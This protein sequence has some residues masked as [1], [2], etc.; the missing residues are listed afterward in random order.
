MR[1]KIS[2]AF[3]QLAVAK[4]ADS[5][6]IADA[7][8]TTIQ[9]L[10]KK[11]YDENVESQVIVNAERGDIEVYILK[12]IVETVVNPKLEISVEDAKAV[13]E[14]LEVG[15]EYPEGGPINS[16]DVQKLFTRKSIGAIKQTVQQRIRA[17]ERNIL[18]NECL[19]MVGEVITGEVYQIHSDEIILTYNTAKD[20]QIELTLLNAD[21]IDKDNPRKIK[22]MKVYVRAVEREKDREDGPIKVFVSRRDAN[23]LRK[24]FE[25]EVPEIQEGLIVIKKIVRS[26]GERAKVA[27]ESTNNR[28]DPVGAC[29]GH[30]GKRIQNIVKELNNENIDVIS[31]SEEPQI[32]IGRALQPAKI[33]P[34]MVHA[35]PKTK[36]AR[37]MLRPDQIKYAIG[38]NGH[39]IRLAQELTGYEIEI[40]RD[41]SDRALEQSDDIDIIDF[42][43]DFGDDVIYQLLEAGLDTARKV[44][45][46][47]KEAVELALTPPQYRDDEFNRLKFERTGIKPRRISPE[48]REYWGKMAGRIIKAIEEEFADDEKSATPKSSGEETNQQAAVDEQAAE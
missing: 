24:L 28:I 35:D 39:N 15:D 6:D 18:Y 11:E 33:D 31:H 21:K 8:K 44:I 3:K 7:I 14:D 45:D 37:V 43:E 13:D 36:K 9:N 34:T 16:P 23:F 20:Q 4:G 40:Y 46:A 1:N 30:K 5:N 19:D 22:R 17:G 12:K 2:D 42:R 26:P 38:R 32:Y 29:V 47:G 48:D 27:V 25:A 10:L 41:I